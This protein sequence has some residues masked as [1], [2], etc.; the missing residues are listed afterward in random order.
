MLWE[1]VSAGAL[2]C[3]RVLWSADFEAYP[4]GGCVRDLLLDR[5]P[6]DWDVATNAMPEQVMELFERVIPTGVKHGTVTV[7]AEDEPIEVTT[8]R[9]ET[10]YS[11]GRHPDAVR[12]NATLEEDLSRRDFT[13][14]AM[15]LA[16]D[17]TVIDLFEG[18]ADLA[19]GI[20]RCVGD[21]VRRFEE[22]GLRM[23]RAVRF[24]AQ[25]NF[26]LTPDTAEAI[27]ACAGG[28]EQIAAERVRVEVEKTL[29]SARPERVRDF[30]E[31][32]LMTERGQGVPGCADSLRDV[33]EQPLL[34]WAG[35]CGLL[36]RDNCVASA[37]RFLEGVR[38]ERRSV[39]ACAAGEELWRSGLPDSDAQWRRA[40]ARYGTDGCRAAAAMGQ[41]CGQSGALSALKQVLEQAP[42]VC[43]EDLA[44]SG[45][46]LA[47][48]GLRGAQIGAAQR[49][50]LEHVLAEP[51]DNRPQV[52]A[53]KLE[54]FLALS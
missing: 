1:Q 9:A 12:F 45:G 6:G 18:R 21:P 30:F 8:F 53:L 43:V 13:I 47:Q 38:M 37:V 34:R 54:E 29:C 19:R 17:G 51:E 23:F 28:A 33:P 15:A 49:Y 20:I 25:L 27:R 4:V 26:K 11:D 5:A 31:L 46:Q 50:L 22:D 10:S 41:A 16:P 52:L 44:L 48:R 3:C 35:L 2:E 42:C 39:R 14:N 7:I 40:L 32:S 24:A 36:L